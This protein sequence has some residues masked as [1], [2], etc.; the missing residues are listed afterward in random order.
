MSIR[1]QFTKLW[2][3]ERPLLQARFLYK[4]TG[5]KL[6][7]QRSKR[8]TIVK[9]EEFCVDKCKKM[10]YIIL[11]KAFCSM[12]LASTNLCEYKRIIKFYRAFF[13]VQSVKAFLW[14]LLFL[15]SV[16]A[17]TQN[18]LDQSFWNFA[19][20]ETPHLTNAF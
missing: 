3:F 13:S 14:N 16:Y 7:E 10:L 18:L 6:V 11:M 15:K 4:L 2:V 12:D 5:C 8:R 17:I 19:P 1:E 9:K 20:R